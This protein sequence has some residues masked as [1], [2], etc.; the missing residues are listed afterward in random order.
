MKPGF[1]LDETV[2]FIMGRPCFV[3]A[4]YAHRLRELGHKIECRAED[5][6]AYTMH[7]LLHLYFKHGADW[8]KEALRILKAGDAACQSANPDAQT[9][10]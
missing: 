9:P 5:E 1:E 7:W 6:Q 3:L 2:R 4:P 8:N 10:P